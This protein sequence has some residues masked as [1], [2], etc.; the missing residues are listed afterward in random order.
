M[1]N[2]KISVVIP[3]YNA[4]IYLN[5]CVDSVLGQTM[6]DIECILVND[7]SIDR[8]YSICKSYEV[9][10]SR[11]K[12]IN[13]K[14]AGSAVARNRGMEL[15]VGKYITFVDADDWLDL[16]M[17]EKLFFYA[18][19]NKAD[20]TICNHSHIYENG[21]SVIQS[22]FGEKICVYNNREDI[23]IFLR[24]FLCKG[25][26]EYR[27]YIK[28]GYPWGRIYNLNTI[29]KNELY[30]PVGLHR[31]EDGIFNMYAAY[32]SRCICLIDEPLYYYRILN[33]SISHRYYSNIVKNTER[34]FFEVKKFAEKYMRKDEIF[35]KGINIRIT[36]WFYKYLT[37]KFFNKFYLK[38]YG[39]MKARKEV[40]KL[41]D[42]Q[43]YS[44][45]YR[46]V[47]FSLMTFYE[48]IFVICMKKHLIEIAF[49]L[50][51]TRELLKNIVKN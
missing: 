29:K 48:K 5:Q 37:C 25:V 46:D 36:T 18:E 44:C 41:L 1:E 22:F 6:T 11:V 21:R 51:K 14:N 12:V 16:H 28:V 26:K 20:I 34:D 15:A 27:P 17:F 35:N 31:T 43:L 38:K 4:E 24:K 40:N 19:K 2:V 10:D 33:S 49:L 7:G 3:V 50:V 42:R 23:N 39:Y 8:S 32:F 13:Q 30:F 47:D 45:A 9:Q